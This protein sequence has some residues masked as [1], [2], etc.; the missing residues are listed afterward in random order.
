M[1]NT[2]TLTFSPNGTAARIIDW[3]EY[4]RTRSSDTFVLY[5]EAETKD[6]YAAFVALD[7][8]EGPSTFEE[9]G[10][11]LTRDGTQWC[12]TITQLDGTTRSCD[13]SNAYPNDWEDVTKLF[14][15]S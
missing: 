13:G 6:V 2:S 1:Y 14:G 12:L 7:T 8:D 15:I 9:E 5:D 11:W 10:E 4:E 3:H